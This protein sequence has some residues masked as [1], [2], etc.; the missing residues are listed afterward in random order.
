LNMLQ[1]KNADELRSIAK[2]Y[3]E[4]KMDVIVTPVT[5]KRWLLKQFG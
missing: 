3:A 5:W 1:A 4:E 2:D